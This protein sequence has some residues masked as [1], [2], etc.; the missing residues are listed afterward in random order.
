MSAEVVK[1]RVIELPF[2]LYDAILGFVQDKSDLC[3]LC[4]VSSILRERATPLLYSTILLS[5]HP[6]SW[7]TTINTDLRFIKP[8]S[9]PPRSR[10]QRSQSAG[11][12]AD[13]YLTLLRQS[14]FRLRR[15]RVHAYR[16]RSYMPR[17]LVLSILE[18]QPELCELSFLVSIT[19][20]PRR[21][22]LIIPSHLAPH[23]IS[24]ETNDDI[25]PI[26][27]ASPRPHIRL[28][29]HMLHFDDPLDH[30]RT[31]SITVKAYAFHRDH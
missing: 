26:V 31:L 21:P 1:P 14:T 30:L 15:F 3:H 8:T 29:Q 17:E 4:L 10:Y 2:D 19:I 18:W 7:C 9:E 22:P 13:D 25:F 12:T 20:D 6:Q 5:H 16:F 24:L 23:L 11:L 27:F 28:R